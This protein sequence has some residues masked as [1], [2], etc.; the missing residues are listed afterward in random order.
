VAADLAEELAEQLRG[1]MPGAEVAVDVDE[2]VGALNPEPDVDLV[3]IV[4]RRMLRAGWDLA[5][6]LTDLP[7]LLGR[8][9]VKAHVSVSLGVGIVSVPALGP[10]DL[11]DRLRDAVAH[12]VDKLLGGDDETIT[13]VAPAAPGSL[14][15]LL[16]MVRAN[17][18]W[19]LTAGLS[20]ALVGAL[21]TGALALAS[22]GV[23]HLADGSSWVRLAA[24]TAGSLLTTCVSL[25]VIHDLWERS[26]A[27]GARRRV[28]LINLATAL[29]IVLGVG[30]LYVALF[31]LTLGG[32]AAL[33]PT[34]VLSHELGHEVGVGQYLKLAWLTS[35]LATLGG[36]LGAAIEN[37]RAVR[38]A[39]YGYR[40]DR[41]EDD[42]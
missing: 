25:I 14:R 22:T 4:R 11:E 5:I 23:W 30:S 32:G 41:D 27:A 36:A 35:S 19:Q 39:A 12:L 7:L 16:G 15:L 38:E 40:P 2:H 6:C 31:A 42:D 9:P 28:V 34:G 18:P 3:K 20:R 17:R 13:Q 10:I 1:R 37:E 26:P 8:R 24:L 33:I 21:G 29:T